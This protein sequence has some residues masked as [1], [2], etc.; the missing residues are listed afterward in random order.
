MLQGIQDPSLLLSAK[1]VWKG[2]GG[3]TASALSY[4]NKEFNGREHLLLSLGQAAGICPRVE[5]SLKKSIPA[6]YKLD[7]AGAHE[8]LTE[9]AMALEQAG[10]GVLL[11][12]WWT[13]KGR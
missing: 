3:L 4:F 5:A 7:S 9:I 10:F 1:E 8:F 13:R 12:A 6:G 11:P 2:S